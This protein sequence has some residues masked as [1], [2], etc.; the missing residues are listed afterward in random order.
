MSSRSSNTGRN[1]SSSNRNALLC[2]HVV[3]P[4]LPVSLT[5]DNPGRRFWG[6]VYYD[7]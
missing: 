7:V 6:C 2:H 3:R 1:N 5:K 4:L